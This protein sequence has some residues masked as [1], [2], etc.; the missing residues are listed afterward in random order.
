M[1]CMYLHFY[2]LTHSF[3]SK[4]KP[5]S[6][7]GS[8]HRKRL[9]VTFT[10]VSVIFLGVRVLKT[11]NGMRISNRMKKNQKKSHR[12]S[13]SQKELFSNPSKNLLFEPPRAASHARPRSN[14]P[15]PPFLTSQ[16]GPPPPP[17]NPSSFISLRG[18]CRNK[19]VLLGGCVTALRSQFF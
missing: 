19:K 11:Q 2:G 6:S 13:N 16:H 5:P 10:F 4:D 12:K 14:Y 15:I 17:P 7:F 1:Y 8:V 9:G 18:V 3:F